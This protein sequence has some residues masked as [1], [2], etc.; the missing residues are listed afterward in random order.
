MTIRFYLWEDKLK[1][2]KKRENNK[3]LNS[4]FDNKELILAK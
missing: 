1:I 2:L 4:D 3:I